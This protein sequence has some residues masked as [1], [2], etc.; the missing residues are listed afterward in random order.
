MQ[1]HGYYVTYSNYA[2]RSIITITRIVVLFCRKIYI[3]L[4]NIFMKPLE[5]KCLI[6]YNI[7]CITTI[8][9]RKGG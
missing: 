1:K 3:F 4:Q 6:C 5:K 2:T 8:K 7:Y 9:A